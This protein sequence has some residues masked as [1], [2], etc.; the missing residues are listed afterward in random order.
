[1]N[2]PL[3]VLLTLMALAAASQRFETCAAPIEW[4]QA[5]PPETS[6]LPLTLTGWNADVIWPGPIPGFDGGGYLWI[7]DHP[8]YRGFPSSGR[9]TSIHNSN[10]IFQLQ[11]FVAPNVLLM[12]SSVEPNDPDPTAPGNHYVK[13]PDEPTGTLS[14]V[15]PARYLFLAVAASS[16]GS[17]GIG[18]IVLNFADGTSS[19]EF[20]LMA[21]DWWNY[22]HSVYW[23]DSL[24]PGAAAIT[25]LARVVLYSE[26]GMNFDNGVY[27]GNGD[28]FALYETD[29]DLA[30]EGL[31]SKVLTS[32][33]FTKPPAIYRK[34]GI[35]PWST[36]VFAV[37]GIANEPSI[38]E[39]SNENPAAVQV[40]VKGPINTVIRLD[41]S[42]DLRSWKPMATVT[43]FVGTVQATDAQVPASK[44]RFYRAVRVE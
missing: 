33:T 20:P 11:P 36:G 18:K 37:S 27:N 24:P 25:G 13:L 40:K 44:A 10:V 12:T 4:V 32:L 16:G 28:G 30:A 43:N 38:V 15:A 34:V 14:L 35:G 2:A 17:G 22:G 9:F 3:T 6:A 8:R 42:D 39:L 31:S 1:M 5:D 26:G 41:I 7:M 19:R 23:I 29:I 21:P